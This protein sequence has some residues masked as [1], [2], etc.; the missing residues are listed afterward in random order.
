MKKLFT[1]LLAITM[2]LSL[3]ACG[4]SAAKEPEVFRVGFGR[5]DITSKVS[6]PLAGYG[7]TLER[8][9]QGYLDLLYATCVA[10]TDEKGETV[11]LYTVDLDLTRT[12]WMEDQRSKITAATGVPAERIMVSATH[13]HSGPDI[14]SQIQMGHAYYD[15][16]TN[17]LVE[18]G[19]QA[20][21]D[22]SAATVKT[23]S[24]EGTGLN[25]VRHVKMSDGNMAGDNFGDKSV[26]VPMEDHHEA[27]R[28][29]QLVQ[30]DRE[31]KK[32]ILMMNFQTHPKLA[33]TAGTPYGQENRPMQTADVVGAVRSYVE[34]NADVLVAYYTGASGNINPLD[35]YVLKNN[36]NA[37]TDL[38]SWGKAAGEIVLA[39]LPGM[40]EVTEPLAV[41]A[42]QKI[43]KAENKD[44]S[45][46]TDVE[47]DA[48]RV[49]PIGFA[50]API[51]MFDTNGLQIKDGS[52]FETTFVL[53]M[54]NGMVPGYYVP[55]QD[56]WEYKTADGSLPYEVGYCH[57]VKGTGEM[58]ANELVS[59]LGE[60]NG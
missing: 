23:G 35:S 60:L 11:L 3:C 33:S 51:E 10:I 47:L 54:A 9:S 39:A 14:L 46:T 50:T 45:G 24:S 48:V 21:E 13:T 55:S 26:A 52:P 28:E 18:A 6:V 59:M 40:K 19:K 15:T 31:G 22:R 16:F 5:A 38:P 7:N 29:I 12:D 27:D 43:V 32:S 36:T 57:F 56:T 2:L 41:S 17:G 1:L 20:M 42:T 44:G 4:Q 49:G 30:F 25:F 8:M 53:T 37:Q 58:F 34:K